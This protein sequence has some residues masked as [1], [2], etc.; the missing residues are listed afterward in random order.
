MGIFCFFLLQKLRY[1]GVGIWRGFRGKVRGRIGNSRDWPGKMEELRECGWSFF[2]Y[3]AEF[4]ERER[5][6]E[7]DRVERGRGVGVRRIVE[8]I[9]A[10]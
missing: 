3:F 1:E 2:L 4:R 8:V 6:R 9:I 5:E 10:S 7:R